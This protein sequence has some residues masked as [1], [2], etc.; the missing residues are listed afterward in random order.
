M[1]N[2]IDEIFHSF[3][4]SRLGQIAASVAVMVV[5]SLILWAEGRGPRTGVWYFVLYG[6]AMGLVAGLV[7]TAVKRRKGQGS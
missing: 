7:L 3:G 4:A 2:L 5:F 1:P 6:G